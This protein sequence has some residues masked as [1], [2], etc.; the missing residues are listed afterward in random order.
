MLATLICKPTLGQYLNINGEMGIDY[1]IWLFVTKK[2][3]IHILYSLVW[4]VWKRCLN[5]KT[6][7]KNEEFKILI[8]IVWLPRKRLRRA[9]SWIMSYIWF[10]C[11]VWCRSKKGTT[12]DV[13]T[14]YSLTTAFH[15]DPGLL[16]SPCPGHGEQRPLGTPPGGIC[17]VSNEQQKTMSPSC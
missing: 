9:A 14:R 8:W 3:K 11:D 2:E 5:L 6:A 17:F 7:R 15:H 12:A 16:C 10:R 4:N 1:F 13:T